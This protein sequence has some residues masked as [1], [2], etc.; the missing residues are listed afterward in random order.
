LSIREEGCKSSYAKTGMNTWWEN[1]GNISLKKGPIESAG[2]RA[3]GVKGGPP[4]SFC[5][6][7]TSKDAGKDRRPCALNSETEY[8]SGKKMSSIS[9]IRKN[10][11]IGK[12]AGS[13]AQYGGLLSVTG[14]FLTGNTGKPF[15]GGGGGR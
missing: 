4:V 7:G 8:E 11:Y 5:H 12:E 1:N 6:R 3:W 2:R 13:C 15:F 14:I 10:S 9:Y